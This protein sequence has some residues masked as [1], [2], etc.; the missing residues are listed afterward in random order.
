MVVV[1]SVVPWYEVLALEYGAS[2]TLTLEYNEVRQY[3]YF[4]TSKAVQKYK[5]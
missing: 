1:G 4:C 3:F 5:Y 2:K